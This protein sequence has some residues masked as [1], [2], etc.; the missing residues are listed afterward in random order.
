MKY[1]IEQKA[2]SYEL[3]T[4]FLMQL[5]RDGREFGF[6][7]DTIHTARFFSNNKD[8]LEKFGTVLS[9]PKDHKHIECKRVRAIERDTPR[10]QEK[11]HARLKAHLEKKG[12]VYQERAKPEI[13]RRFNY[14]LNIHS[15]SSGQ[16]FR[17][18]IKNTRKLNEKKGKFSSYGLSINGS[19]LPLF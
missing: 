3:I 13:N 5:H 19:T 6:Y 1:Y 9:A 7:F 12:I 10:Q 14:Y 18:H 16:S 4:E 2:H 15:Q 17:L 8:F 11:R